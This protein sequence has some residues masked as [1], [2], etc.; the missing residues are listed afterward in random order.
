MHVYVALSHW[1]RTWR[2][3]ETKI[4][5]DNGNTSH[6]HSMADYPSRSGTGQCCRMGT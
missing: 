2:L 4:E 1:T 6:T 3:I 5:I